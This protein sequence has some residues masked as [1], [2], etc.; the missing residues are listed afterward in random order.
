MS[1]RSSSAD[2]RFAKES[3]AEREIADLADPVLDELGFNVVEA[4]SGE[5]ALAALDRIPDLR[6][7]VTDHLMPG[8]EGVELARQVKL[9]RPNLACLIISGYA[10]VEGIAPDLPRLTKP[11]KAE[12][13]R[14][15]LA[16]TGFGSSR[17]LT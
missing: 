6:L 15:G 13:L 16:A 4:S 2:R 17:G 1:S 5:A 8:M 12:E 3:G 11:F 14:E 9:S 10:D 7:L